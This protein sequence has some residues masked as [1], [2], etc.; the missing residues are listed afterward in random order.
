MR[1]EYAYQWP[2]TDVSQQT[3][4]EGAGHPLRWIS[5]GR[6][7]YAPQVDTRLLSQ[8][9]R[10]CV[11]HQRIQISRRAIQASDKFRNRLALFLRMFVALQ[12]LAQE[13]GV[14]FE[15]IKLVLEIV[16]DSERRP[17]QI[18]EGRGVQLHGRCSFHRVKLIIPTKLYEMG[19]IAL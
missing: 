13:R 6:L 12:T 1:I 15:S 10:L 2:R 5:C 11:S 8:I 7:D 19:S 4:T 9:E 17:T 18:F 3:S 16:N 14:Q